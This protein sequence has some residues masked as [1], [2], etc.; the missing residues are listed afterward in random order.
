MNQIHHPLHCGNKDPMVSLG[1]AIG[2]R[3]TLPLNSTGVIPAEV[4]ERLLLDCR[5]DIATALYAG[6]ASSALAAVAAGSIHLSQHV[7][8]G[9]LTWKTAFKILLEASVNLR[10]VNHFG[11]RAVRTALY[12]GP[13]FYNALAEAA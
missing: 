12:A 5:F 8:T 6:G 10:L 11:R 3:N 13:R 9:S 2:F 7:V 1:D 4:I